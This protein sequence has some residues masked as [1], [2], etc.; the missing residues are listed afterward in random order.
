MLWYAI[1]TKDNTQGYLLFLET[2]VLQV[3]LN[4]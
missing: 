3:L 1:I 2:H 4:G